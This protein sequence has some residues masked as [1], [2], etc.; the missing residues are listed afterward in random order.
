MACDPKATNKPS[1]FTPSAVKGVAKRTKAY[2]S[3]LYSLMAGRFSAEELAAFR[4]KARAHAGGKTKADLR[5]GKTAAE[6]VDDLADGFEIDAEPNT[7]VWVAL[8]VPPGVADQL[9]TI[10]NGE[11]A[12]DLHLTLAYLGDVGDYSTL[13]LAKALVAIEDCVR[14]NAPISGVVSGVGRF[15]APMQ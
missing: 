1:D 6:V 14:W 2:Q 12:E 13:Q 4:K 11:A 5:A 9:A 15:D 3:K 10:E 8:R 7:S